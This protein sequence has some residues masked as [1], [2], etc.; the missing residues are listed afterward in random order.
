MPEDILWMK[1][2]VSRWSKSYNG[3][4]ELEQ[5]YREMEEQ[6]ILTTPAQIRIYELSEGP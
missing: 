3:T 6:A 4:V 2:I 5:R 1:V